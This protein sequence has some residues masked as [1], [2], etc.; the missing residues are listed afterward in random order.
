[1]VSVL[2]TLGALAVW[3]RGVLNDLSKWAAT[4]IW[5]RYYLDSL[6]L[7]NGLL[8]GT[9]VLP[10]W[11]RSTWPRLS[12]TKVTWLWRMCHSLPSRPHRWIRRRRSDG[13]V[14]VDESATCFGSASLGMM[15]FLVVPLYSLKGRVSS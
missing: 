4:A 1:M 15:L 2:D 13:D 11:S 3:G 14:A 12:V 8:G 10:G 7:D 6:A 9:G 5:Q